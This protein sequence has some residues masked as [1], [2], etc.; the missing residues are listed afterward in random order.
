MKRRKSEAASSLRASKMMSRV[1]SNAKMPASARTK[2]MRTR[3]RTRT[4]VN[5]VGKDVGVD[6]EKPFS[7]T[8][9]Y[10]T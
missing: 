1:N 7:P 10:D 5:V 9:A 2:M 6:V 8:D 3:T 4:M